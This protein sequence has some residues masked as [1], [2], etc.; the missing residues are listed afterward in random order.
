M[1]LK[2][3]ETRHHLVEREPDGEPYCS[4]CGLYSPSEE[5]Q[6]CIPFGYETTDAVDKA[7]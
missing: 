2:I 4:R 6:F 1:T 7:A 3:I 5:E